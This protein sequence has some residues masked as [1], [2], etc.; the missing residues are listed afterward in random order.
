MLKASPISLNTISYNGVIRMLE[1]IRDVSPN[2]PCVEHVYVDTGMRKYMSQKY[3][4]L[5]KW[6]TL[7]STSR[8]WW[9][10]LATNSPPVDSQSRKRQML[11]IK[12]SVQ[13]SA[14][15]GNHGRFHW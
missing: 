14:C 8:N 9:Q 10:L 3:I 11:P 15:D 4:I 12:W 6:E 7:N 2:P 1:T 13:V 5:C